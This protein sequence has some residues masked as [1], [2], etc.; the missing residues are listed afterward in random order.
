LAAPLSS[1][2]VAAVVAVNRVRPGA[3]RVRIRTRT[4]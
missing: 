2:A 3:D 1:L 4:R